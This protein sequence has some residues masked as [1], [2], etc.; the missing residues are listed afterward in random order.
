MGMVDLRRLVHGLW[1]T[2]TPT[3]RG[4][5][6]VGARPKAA[7]LVL[8]AVASSACAAED[9][10]PVET[11]ISA[12]SA[13]GPLNLDL[14]FVIDNGPGM[15][16][17]QA[18]LVDQIP[19]MMKV[20]AG[21]AGGFPA[22]HIAVISTDMGALSDRSDKTGCSETGDE[23]AFQF[24]PRG[25]CTDATLTHGAT[26]LST[27]GGAV[28][29]TVVTALTSVVQCILPLGE[30][31]CQYVHPLAAIARALGA[32]GAQAPASN[33]GFLRPDAILA[34]IILSN[35]D[36]CS[37]GSP[38]RTPL[39]SLNG[40]PDNLINAYGPLTTY[41][42]NEFGHLCVNPHSNGA[43][44]NPP[45]SP[46]QGQGTPPT[47]DLTNCTSNEGGLL[48]PVGTFVDEIRKLKPLP[49]RQIM[50]GLIAAP[51]SPYTVAWVPTSDPT[52]PAGQL[53]PEAEHACGAGDGAGT[54][55][56][57]TDLA[58]DGS[59]GDPSVRLTQFAGTF[60]TNGMTGS[61][62]YPSYASTM[63][64]LTARIAANLSTPYVGSGSGGASGT[65]FVDGSAG[66]GD[67]GSVSTGGSGGSGVSGSAG[68]SNGGGFN[69]RG[70]SGIVSG[71]QPGCGGCNVG[72]AST[73][74]SGLV[75]LVIF[76]AILRR[77]SRRCADHG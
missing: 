38:T 68:S 50:V 6:R 61:V 42:C 4:H 30:S 59:F 34:I 77:R 39:Y 11:T 19:P 62:C 13:P 28:D 46:T 70:G 36:D 48:T 27:G 7:L 10:A 56:N 53:W 49:D 15:A 20:F 63:V 3:S 69:G 14:L 55:P 18:K 16:P 25:T 32:D 52:A 35:Q 45:E 41:R 9:G 75:L 60:G 29:D 24:Q 37:A 57:A 66:P 40:G 54:N 22:A 2:N 23:G 26:F 31:G 33:A 74:S 76:P 21:L 72:V 58:T 43:V 73:P 47:L 5:G 65:A 1:E 64:S 67:G 17:M 71:L 44:Q 12:V 51:V 8:V